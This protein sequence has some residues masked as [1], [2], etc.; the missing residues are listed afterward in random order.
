MNTQKTQLSPSLGGAIPRLLVVP[1]R[2]F[3]RLANLFSKGLARLWLLALSG[4][5]LAG[6]IAPIYGQTVAPAFAGSYTITPL[7]AAST[8][9]PNYGGLVFQQGN[10]DVLLLGGNSEA[11]SGEIDAVTVV[12]TGVHITGFGAATQF[13]T[14]PYIDGGLIYAPN[15]DL[16]FM[17]YTS[18]NQI[19][20]LKAGWTTTSKTVD[21]PVGGTGGTFQMVP[22]GYN[23]AGN[24]I[25]ASYSNSSYC[26]SSLT[27]DG[28]GP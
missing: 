1:A 25:I 18:S 8:V 7:G 10:S 28:A 19:G 15:G 9:P 13:K 16:L 2:S 21:N 11:A 26:A 22:A 3:H 23:G 4:V 14:A 5:L 12:R 6:V 20:Q 17:A 27:P 24:F